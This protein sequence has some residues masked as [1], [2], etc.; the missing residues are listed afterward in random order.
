VS[1]ASSAEL[2]GVR[3]VTAQEL[4]G[5]LDAGQAVAFDARRQVDYA[6][7]HISGAVSMPQDEVAA[8]LSELPAD[9]LAVFYCT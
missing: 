3:R 4:K 8:R 5:K 6:R 7:R 9:K 2:A 1:E